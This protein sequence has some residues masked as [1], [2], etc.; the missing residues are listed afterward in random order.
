[1]LSPMHPDTGGRFTLR[2]SEHDETLARYELTLAT[3]SSEWSARANVALADGSIDFADWHGDGEPP[4]WLL[5][6]ARAALRSAWRAHA[7]QGWPRRLTRWRDAP[8][9]AEPPSTGD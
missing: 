1:M 9:R 7:E 6:Y 5:Q 2:L 4:A 8:S 3:P